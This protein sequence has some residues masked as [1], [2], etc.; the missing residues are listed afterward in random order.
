MNTVNDES[1]KNE[2]FDEQEQDTE[3]QGQLDFERAKDVV[4]EKISGEKKLRE[5]IQKVQKVQ[6]KEI[7]YTC[8]SIFL[9]RII[10]CSCYYSINWPNYVI[11]CNAFELYGKN[12]KIC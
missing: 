10:N 8:K 3:E 11:H 2:E 12:E 9:D 1:L 4:K 7:C 5:N 6:S